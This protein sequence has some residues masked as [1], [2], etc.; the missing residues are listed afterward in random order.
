MGD[1]IHPKV[2][3]H[4]N[5]SVEKTH[6]WTA[7]A[8]RATGRVAVAL[9]AS[10]GGLHEKA[11][12]LA[13]QAFKGQPDILANRGN[14]DMYVGEYIPS[15]RSVS[16]TNS[17]I[18]AD[19]WPRGALPSVSPD[20]EK[21]LAAIAHAFTHLL[22][23]RSPRAELIICQG[24][25]ETLSQVALSKWAKRFNASEPAKLRPGQK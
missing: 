3:L 20:H 14:F 22:A 12:D 8:D 13:C 21:D 25:G 24:T 18:L 23:S 15:T 11:F 7:I 17:G 10:R 2:W 19:K 1:W 9:V 16:V 4:G 5:P 6:T